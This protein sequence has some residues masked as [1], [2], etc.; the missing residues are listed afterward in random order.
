MLIIF[1]RDEKMVSRAID[2][3]EQLEKLLARHDALI[4]GRLTSSSNYLVQEEPEEEEAE[5][6]FRRY[7]YSY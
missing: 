6:L 4:S 7:V 5:Q 1:S 3:N 2:L